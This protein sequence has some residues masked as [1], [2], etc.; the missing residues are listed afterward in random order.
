MTNKHLGR[1]GACSH[2]GT[3]EQTGKLQL[4]MLACNCNACPPEQSASYYNSH[5]RHVKHHLLVKCLTE[6]KVIYQYHAI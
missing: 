5:L 4:W 2:S 1:V 3:I 6:E